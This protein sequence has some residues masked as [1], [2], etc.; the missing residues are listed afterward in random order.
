MNVPSNVTLEM[1]IMVV[2]IPISQCAVGQVMVDADIVV[3]KTIQIAAEMV[4]V[5]EEQVSVQVAGLLLG[6]RL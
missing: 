2:V 1:D 3:Q 5:P 6:T 4:C